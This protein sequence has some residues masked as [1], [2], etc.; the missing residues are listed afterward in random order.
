M[1]TNTDLLHTIALL[2]VANV[3]DVNAKTLIG[4]CGSAEAVFR[5]SKATLL[6][7]PSIGEA[8]ATAIM[9]FK[10]F[11]F[12]EA[13]L[14]FMAKHNIDAFIYYETEYPTRLKAFID[15]PTILFRKGNWDANAQHRNVAI[16]GTRVPTD[17]GIA[18]T[19]KLCADLKPYNVSI[20]SGLAY[21]IDVTAHRASIANNIP[22]AGVLAHG[23][24]R[25]YPASN[26]SVAER[27]VMAEN[28][29]A[30]LTEFPT[31]TAPER[32]NFPQRN[33]I[34]AA[35][36]DVVVVVET[37]RKGGSMITA[38]IANQYSRD[39]FALPGKTTDANSV[40]CNLLIKTHRA[41]LL[42][43]AADIAYIM[44]WELN[45]KKNAKKAVQARLFLENLPA[46]EA[47]IAHVLGI[48]PT[49]IDTL[50]QK[51]NIPLHRIATLLLT[52]ELNG[53]IR[54]LPGSRYS[55]S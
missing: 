22:T 4:H 53:I 12:A 40:G 27:M 46:E 17:Y 37:A 32:E 25:I 39:V 1:Q 7:I 19:E 26:R 9:E 11:S 3:G 10:N 55:L 24:D 54:S 33:R 36:S 45:E 52:M 29:G 23:L 6:K 16:V 18:F 38:N 2:R 43:S 5:S 35:L 15:A 51:T 14:N 34:V 41:A 8:I 13:E 21:G 49:M 30:L 44:G 28:G 20:V 48:E 31:D 47:A 50:V 42:E